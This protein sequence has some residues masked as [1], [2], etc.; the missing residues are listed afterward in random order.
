M[1]LRLFACLSCQLSSLHFTVRVQRLESD[2]ITELMLHGGLV[3]SI[4][5][6][7]FEYVLENQIGVSGVG[8]WVGV[9]VG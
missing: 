4:F 3:F 1:S 9:W 8:G 7:L 2:L 6:F 5:R